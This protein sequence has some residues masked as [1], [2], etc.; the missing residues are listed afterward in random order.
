[1]HVTKSDWNKILSALSKL[2]DVN[3]WGGMFKL[4]LAS[5]SFQYYIDWHRKW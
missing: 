5:S 2:Y 1:M 4:K 3:I